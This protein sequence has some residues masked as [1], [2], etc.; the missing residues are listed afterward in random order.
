MA[1]IDGDGYTFDIIEW[2]EHGGERDGRDSPYYHSG[3]PSEKQLLDD[4]VKLTGEL[5]YRD[6]VSTYYTI[7]SPDG[8]LPDEL[9]ASVDDAAGY[10]EEYA[11]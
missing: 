3:A 4:A 7:H 6:E 2:W 9:A 8:W 1:L 10:Y 5:T 11:G